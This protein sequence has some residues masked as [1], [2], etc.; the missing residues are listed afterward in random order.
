MHGEVLALLRQWR[1]EL[2]AAAMTVPL[3]LPALHA[4]QARTAAQFPTVTHAIEQVRN[5]ALTS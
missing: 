5:V 3:D 2:D 1:D 4:S